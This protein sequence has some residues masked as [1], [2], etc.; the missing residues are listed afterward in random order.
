MQ[1]CVDAVVVIYRWV[2]PVLVHSFTDYDTYRL[3]YVNIEPSNTDTSVRAT[4]TEYVR[5]W[6]HTVVCRL[7]PDTYVAGT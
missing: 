7:I 6:Y 2:V 5:T 3:V 1:W 4:S